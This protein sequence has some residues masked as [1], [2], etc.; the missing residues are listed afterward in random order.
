M[1]SSETS[2][3]ASLARLQ[4]IDR[5]RRD[6]LDRIAALEREIGEIEAEIGAQRAAEAAIGVQ[7]EEL[8]T[9]LQE[10]ERVFEAEGT[11]MKERRMRLNRVRNEKELQ[12]LRHEIEIGKE[13]NQQLEEQ[14]IAGLEARDA[15]HESRTQAQARVAELESQAVEKI[16]NNRARIEEMRREL[17]SDR[18]DREALRG[19]ID[20]A[21]LQRYEMLF[22]RRAGTAVVAV[23]GGICQGCHRTIPPQLFIELQRHRDAVHECPVCRRILHW[24]PKPAPAGD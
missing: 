4:E 13:A 5:V 15:L 20:P 12:A 24:Q 1:D 19:R 22:E 16:A 10:Q 17:D 3:I 7:V 23:E 21:L 2:G 11:R 9:R 18:E 8:E 6:R 14:L